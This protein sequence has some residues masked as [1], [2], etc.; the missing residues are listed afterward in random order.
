MEILTDREAR[1]LGCLIEKAMT[2]PDHYPLTVNAL[3]AACNQKSNRHPIVA[4]DEATVQAALA[5]LDAKHLIGVTRV[6][7]GRALK[8]RHHADEV[9]RV[10]AGQLAVLAVLLLR[11]PQTPGELRARTER[12]VGAGRDVEEILRGL[13]TRDDPLVEQLDRRPGQRESR[14]R[15]LLT[16]SAAEE[17]EERAEEEVGERAAPAGPDL[18]ERLAALEGRVEALLRHL[19]LDRSDI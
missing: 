18:E 5:S 10:D 14:Y 7:G 4:Y 16:T 2:T 15:T 8:Y 11:G 17:I 12:Y 6:S 3:T 9:L 19:G 13:I 1:A